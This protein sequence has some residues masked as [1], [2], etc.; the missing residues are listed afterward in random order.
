ML[1]S[2]RG[3]ARGVLGLCR[4]ASSRRLT[5]P[6][7]RLVHRYSTRRRASGPRN[8]AQGTAPPAPHSHGATSPPEPSAPSLASSRTFLREVYLKDF[9][10][11]SEQ[12]LQ[13]EPGLNVIT[14]GC[15]GPGW[16]QKQVLG[17]F[18]IGGWHPHLQPAQS[19][20]ALATEPIRALPQEPSLSITDSSPAQLPSTAAPAGESG[21]GKS[22]LVEAL[23]QILGSPAPD[24]AVRQPAE[25]AVIEG[26]VALAPADRPL[27]M[28][29]LG[30]LGLPP[31]AMPPTGDLLLRREL[32]KGGV[33]GQ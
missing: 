29:L 33:G 25:M 3:H 12:R 21:A 19:S 2:S 1:A 31:R 18:L 22:V 8:A 23:G 17:T 4:T 9:A 10:L 28:R 7:V 14:G 13:L 16:A 24:E 30:E 5:P 15:W 26:V 20:E 6:I 32:L 11:V 27:L